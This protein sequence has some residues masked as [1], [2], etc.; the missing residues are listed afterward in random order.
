MFQETTP[1]LLLLSMLQ[2]TVDLVYMLQWILERL[3]L[4]CVRVHTAWGLCVS[5]THPAGSQPPHDVIYR[6]SIRQSPLP[7]SG[8]CNNS[9]MG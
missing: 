2:S 8:K 5:P 3:A 7:Q 4:Y 1:L 9:D 6:W